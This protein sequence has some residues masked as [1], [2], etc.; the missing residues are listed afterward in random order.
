MMT[1]EF[2]LWDFDGIDVA[3]VYYKGAI[4]YFCLD[5][6]KRKVFNDFRRMLK[7]VKNK[8]A[9]TRNGDILWIK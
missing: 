8:K 9:K 4:K 2:Y 1:T 3:P 7:H 5:D 6:G